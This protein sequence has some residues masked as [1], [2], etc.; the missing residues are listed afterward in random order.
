[1]TTG[2]RRKSLDDLTP[3]QRA[4]VEAVQA[5]WHTPEAREAEIRDREA[6]AE[7]HR[8]TGRI[9][10]VPLDSEED[11]QFRGLAKELKG[12]REKAG[13]SLAIIAER[14]GIDQG[15][16]SRLENGR[17]NPTI[18]TLMRYAKAIGGRIDWS[19]KPVGE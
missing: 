13:L 3:E 11:L 7:E 2:H 17:G 10:T 18:Q 12:Q 9:A 8:L 16:L 14:S 15:A 5:K 6:L 19:F 4:R 1:M